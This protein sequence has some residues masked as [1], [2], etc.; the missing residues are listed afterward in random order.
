MGVIKPWIDEKPGHFPNKVSFGVKTSFKI[1]DGHH[2]H[3][4]RQLNHHGNQIF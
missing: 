1:Q 3:K 4:N 2:F